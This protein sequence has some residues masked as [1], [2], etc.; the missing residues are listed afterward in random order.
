MWRAYAYCRQQIARRRYVWYTLLTPNA[1][2]AASAI[3]ALVAITTYATIINAVINSLLAVV[4]YNAL[5][6]AL[7]K[8]NLFPSITRHEFKQAS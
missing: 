4:L 7:F 3:S 5:R 8:A 2:K 1:E 6:P